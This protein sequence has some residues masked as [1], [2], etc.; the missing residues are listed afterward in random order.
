MAPERQRQ[1]DYE[2]SSG[3]HAPGYLA[4]R[5]VGASF[6][7]ADLVIFIFIFAGYVFV[8]CI[9]TRS[10]STGCGFRRSGKGVAGSLQI[11]GNGLIFVQ[12]KEAGIGTDK[13]FVEDATGQLVEFILLQRFKHADSDL[14]GD[15]NL[16]Q[17]DVALFALQFQFLTKGRQ[18]SLPLSPDGFY[19][20]EKQSHSH[21]RALRET[22]GGRRERRE[23]QTRLRLSLR[24]EMTK[25]K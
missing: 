16:L 17:C 9:F 3:E 8:R 24:V 20:V 5:G 22:G 6:Q 21:S 13:T 15:G 2:Q 4:R 11:I 19:S 25:L 18:T 23:L 7:A 10:L 12:A 1:R 14:G